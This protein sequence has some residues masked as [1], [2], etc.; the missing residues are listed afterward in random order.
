MSG[1]ASGHGMVS[2]MIHPNIRFLELIFNEG[3]YDTIMLG[4]YTK[5]AK[6]YG[7]HVRLCLNALSLNLI[8]GNTDHENQQNDLRL[9]LAKACE[10]AISIVKTYAAS[11]NAEL[12]VRYGADVGPSYQA[13]SVAVADLDYSIWFS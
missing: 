1:N 12:F 2:L 3:S 9:Y 10:S 13:N 7:E 6:V 5:F 4:I 8:T 11:D